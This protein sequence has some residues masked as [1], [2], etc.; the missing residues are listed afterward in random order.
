MPPHAPGFTAEFAEGAQRVESNS[1]RLLCGLCASAVSLTRGRLSSA[2]VVDGRALGLAFDAHVAERLGF[3]C[4]AE[5]RGRGVA[6]DEGDA[7]L[8]GR[9]FEARGEVDGVADERV[10]EPAG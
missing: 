5:E 9:P 7:G 1:L 3:V 2:D 4:V 10:F 8:L 6:D